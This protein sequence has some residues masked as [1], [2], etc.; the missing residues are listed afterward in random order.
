[1]IWYEELSAEGERL[2]LYA[3]GEE[4]P[5]RGWEALDYLTGEFGRVQMESALPRGEGIFITTRE[6]RDKYLELLTY[7]SRFMATGPGWPGA[8]LTFRGIPII[9]NREVP[10]HT[11]YMVDKGTIVGGITDLL[12]QEG[13]LTDIGRAT[14]TFWRGE[15][16]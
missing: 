9:A 5:L 10:P 4:D 8:V 15:G 13:V 6:V 11:I 14:H 7:E 12:P 2:A 3:L 16:R 1:M